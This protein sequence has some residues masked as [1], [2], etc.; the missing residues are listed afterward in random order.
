MNPWT[1]PRLQN[2]TCAAK[3][4]MSSLLSSMNG[5][6]PIGKTPASCFP[7][8]AA[9]NRERATAAAPPLKARRN[10][11]LSFILST[12]SEED[13]IPTR[14]EFRRIHTRN[15]FQLLECFEIALFDAAFDQSLRG[16]HADIEDRRH[17][18]R[19][20]SVHVDLGQSLPQKA[21]DALEF[22]VRTLSANLH[23]LRDGVHPLGFGANI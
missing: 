21:H 4:S 7:G 17:L 20:R 6:K 23:H 11:R 14:F 22:I 18:H 16:G 1:P 13:A 5:E 10:P 2:F 8:A 3:P 15:L 19:G 12:P 9:A